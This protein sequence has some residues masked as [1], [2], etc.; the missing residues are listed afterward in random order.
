MYRCHLDRLKARLATL[1]PGHSVD[2]VG[3]ESDYEA[4]INMV[5]P[6]Q[7]LP[8]THRLHSFVPCIA[9]PP[10]PLANQRRGRVFKICTCNI[11]CVRCLCVGAKNSKLVPILDA[12][13]CNTPQNLR[14]GLNPRQVDIVDAYEGRPG[15]I[16]GNVARREGE[17]RRSVMPPPPSSPTTMPSF[18]GT[19]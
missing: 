4:A 17:Q 11:S 18:S 14:P 13:R 16:L 12:D 7:L 2:F 15:I 1:F 6:M 9:P 5:Y 8:T 19:T 3:V 10:P